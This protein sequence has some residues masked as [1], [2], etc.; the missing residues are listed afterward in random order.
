MSASPPSAP[1]TGLDAVAG[2]YECLSAG[3]I[4]AETVLDASSPSV[5]ILASLQ[6]R[7][8]VRVRADPSTA[9]RLPVWTLGH[10]W[11]FVRPT[12]VWAVLGLLIWWSWHT[13][14]IYFTTYF[15]AYMTLE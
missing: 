10:R 6:Q 8:D 9:R 1:A 13:H 14:F 3:R 15:R 5:L 2:G 7:A 4:A 11:H 12:W